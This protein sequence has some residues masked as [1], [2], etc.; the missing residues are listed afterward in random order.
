MTEKYGSKGFKIPSNPIDAEGI[1]KSGHGPSMRTLFLLGKRFEVN[2]TRSNN[3]LGLKFRSVK[4]SLLD[5][6]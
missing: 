5:Q 3:E 4:E 6:A 1:K 2:S